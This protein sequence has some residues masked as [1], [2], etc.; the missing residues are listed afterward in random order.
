MESPARTV[1]PVIDQ[2]LDMIPHRLS[3][4]AVG[5]AQVIDAPGVV[6]LD[7]AVS[8]L[9]GSLSKWLTKKWTLK[10]RKK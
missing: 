2:L 1:E 6:E 5:D 9:G 3:E 4:G 7:G 8:T 10:Q